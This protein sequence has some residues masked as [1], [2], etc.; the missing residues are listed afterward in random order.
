MKPV[1]LF[2]V[3]SLLP[4]RAS[5]LAA[6]VAL[7]MIPVAHAEDLLGDALAKGKTNLELRYRLENVEQDP[8]AKTA[9][10]STLRTR[11]R[12][13]SG[14]WAQTSL[15]LE[16]DNVSRVGDDR[17]NDTPQRQGHLSDGG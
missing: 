4:A 10:A 3:S 13:T 1:T 7:A 5:L 14:E 12:Y 9:N 16:M 17:Y 15:M 11:V 6:A 8:M 2:S